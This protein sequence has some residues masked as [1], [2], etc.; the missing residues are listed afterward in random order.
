[1]SDSSRAVRA[2]VTHDEGYRLTLQVPLNMEEWTDE[3]LLAWVAEVTADAMEVA[4]TFTCKVP[5]KAPS[6]TTLL[7]RT[8]NDQW[9]LVPPREAQPERNRLTPY[10]EAP[11]TNGGGPVDPAKAPL[12]PVNPNTRK[13][14]EAIQ[15]GD[16]S[17]E[18]TVAS[19][20]SHSALPEHVVRDHLKRLMKA[21]LVSRQFHGKKHIYNRL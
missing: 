17:K 9:E 14:L 13:V 10:D 16:H 6:H 2:W 15:S 20:T 12:V 11:G 21:G 18:A 19:I 5:V 8:G 1:M 7:Y 4:Q 3:R